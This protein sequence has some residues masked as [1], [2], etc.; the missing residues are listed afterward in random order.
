VVREPVEQ[1][2]GHLRVLDA[3]MMPPL[4]IVWYVAREPEAR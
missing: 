1:R 3:L 2:R 4:W